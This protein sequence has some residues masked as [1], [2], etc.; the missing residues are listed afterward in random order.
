MRHEVRLN[1][2]LDGGT[3]FFMKRMLP[4][5]L[6]LSRICL[7]PPIAI[8]AL[9]QSPAWDIAACVVFVIAAVTDYLDGHLARISRTA[10]L[11]GRMMD[12][13]ADKLLVC[14]VILLLVHVGKIGGLTFWAGCLIILREIFVSGL[15]EYVATLGKAILVIDLSKLKTGV[16]MTALGALLAGSPSQAEPVLYAGYLAGVVL[17][18]VAAGL[19]LWTG[20]IYL[21]KCLRIIAT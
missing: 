12:P 1:G 2:G 9:Q 7:I 16:Q 6:T 19:S 8:L 13:I 10:S 11:L 14:T 4:N 5:L 18:W 21:R 17:L 20:G 15:R 3:S